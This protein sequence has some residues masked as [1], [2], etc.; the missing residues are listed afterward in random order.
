MRKMRICTI[1]SCCLALLLALAAC[2]GS[3]SSGKSDS[4]G[5]PDAPQGYEGTWR[6]V[7]EGTEYWLEL[8]K[9][10]R[11]FQYD[12]QLDLVTTGSW[13]ETEEGVLV[14]REFL[15]P[16][17]MEFS[18]SMFE[19]PLIDN[20]EGDLLMRGVDDMRFTRAEDLEVPRTTVQ[21]LDSYLWIDPKSEYELCFYWDGSWEIYDSGYED[22]VEGDEDGT[23]ID[24]YAIT[25]TTLDGEDLELTL[26][27]EGTQ[28][29]GYR[30]MVFVRSDILAGREDE[31]GEYGEVYWEIYAYAFYG[32]WEYEDYYVWVDIREDGTYEWVDGDN[33]SSGSYTMEEDELVL[34]SGLRFSLDESGG[35]IDSDGDALFRSQ[36][37]DDVSGAVTLTAA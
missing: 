1:F 32:C 31:E 24:G 27:E 15:V 29:T 23:A 7:S 5:E 10:G 9:N 26:S 8:G 3:D 16:S 30:D 4:T 11:I 19:L 25:L 20:G 18:P 13:V 2:G 37:P 36:L 6:H 21:T 17:D 33:A 34:D 28:I 22:L 14:T 12:V 35:L